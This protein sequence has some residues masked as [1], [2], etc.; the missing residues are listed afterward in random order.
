MHQVLMVKNLLPPLFSEGTFITVHRQIVRLGASISLSAMKSFAQG[1]LDI[2]SETIKSHI[3][4]HK[5]DFHAFNRDMIELW[6]NKNPDD[7]IKVNFT[8]IVKLW[9]SL[10]C[11]CQEWETQPHAHFNANFKSINIC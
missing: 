8:K 7:Q 11:R 1:Y 6:A 9:L 10:V 5:D 3:A 4:T 2:S